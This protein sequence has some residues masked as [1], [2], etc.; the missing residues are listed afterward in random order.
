MPDGANT[1]RETRGFEA[2]VAKLLRLMVHSVYSEQ[3]VFLRELISNASDA[4]DKLR[5]EALTD[6]SLLAGDPDFAITVT[7]DKEANTL[8]ISD[9]GI[10]MAREDLIENLGTIARSGTAS[11]LDKLSGDAKSDV[12]LIGQ[13]GVGFYASFMVADNVQVISRRAGSKTAH[14][15]ESMGEGSYTIDT[16]ERDSRGT[17]IILHIKEDST[18]FLERFR[19]QSIIKSYSD[20]VPVPIRIIEADKRDDE[21]AKEQVNE[22]SALW[23][24]DKTSITEEQHTEFYRHIGQ[25][26]DEPIFRLH[27]Q[28]EGMQSYTVLLYVP[29]E[30]PMDLFDPAR[31][32]RVKLYVKKVFISDDSAELLPGW[33]RFLR[34]VVDSDDLPLNISR[35]ML[36][37]NPVVKRMAGAITKKVVSELSKLAEKDSDKFIKIWQAF[38][39]VIKEGLYED[40]ERRDQLLKLARFRST[41]GDG[42]TSLADYVS[43]MKDKQTSLYYITGDSEDTVS[44]SPQLEGFKARGI[45]VLLLSD[46]VD[47]FWLQMITDFDGKPFKSIT[48]GGSDLDEIEGDQTADDTSGAKDAVKEGDLIVLITL[49]KEVLGETVSDIRSTNRLTETAAC[50]V[51]DDS[52]MDMHLERLL[53]ATNKGGA[54]TPKVLEINP[55]AELVKAMADRAGGEGA[56]DALADSAWLLFDQA[57]IIEGLSP[58]DAG[59]FA[60]RLS[61]ALAKGLI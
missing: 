55:K 49:M 3:E 36:Q 22:G 42:W 39:P 33:L 9:N 10:G 60:K 58:L 59:S 23:T 34:G 2:E 53:K 16:A 61:G 20:H 8:T 45:E 11:F 57:R 27:Y 29:T 31:K 30:R 15:W 43:R 46:P 50:L 44:R 4:C 19:L 6:D 13:F 48:R 28:A 51:A 12:S 5:Y 17:D 54:D 14:M 41:Q 25:G 37:N 40:F 1:A 7:A 24:R 32:H 47:D 18:E 38:G 21:A 56:V 35:E 26:Y 52:G